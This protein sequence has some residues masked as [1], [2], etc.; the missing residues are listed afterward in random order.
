MESGPGE[1]V[2]AEQRA[3]ERPPQAAGTPHRPA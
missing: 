2:P 1:I 3:E